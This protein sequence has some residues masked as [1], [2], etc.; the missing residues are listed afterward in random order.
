MNARTNKRRRVGRVDRRQLPDP[1]L[2]PVRLYSSRA[3]ALAT[4]PRP[5]G[6]G[7]GDLVRAFALRIGLLVGGLFGVGRAF[8]TGLDNRA[9]ADRPPRLRGLSGYEGAA[10]GRR[11]DGWFTSNKSANAQ[12]KTSAKSLRARARHLTRNNPHA[13]SAV[14]KLVGATVGVGIPPTSA[15]GIEALDKEANA[16]FSEWSSECQVSGCGGF[17]ALVA[18]AARA[19]FESGEV[20]VRRRPR[21]LEDNLTVPLQLE[22]LE[23][24]LLDQ[25]DNRTLPNGGQVI[26]GVEFDAVGRPVAY[27]LLTSHPGDDHARL[28]SRTGSNRVRLSRARIAH[29]FE[30]QRPGQARGVPWLA[31]VIRRMRDFD[32]YTDAERLRKKIEACLTAWVKGGDEYDGG[33]PA[34]VDGLAPTRVTDSEGI[35][36]EQVEPGLILYL[37]DGKEVVFNAPHTIG[38]YAEFAKVELHG[39]AAGAR[40]TYELLTGDLEKVNFSSI[41]SGKLTWNRT[42]DTLRAHAVIPLLCDRLYDWFV[43]AAISAGLLPDLVEVGAL[44]GRTRPLRRWPRRWHPPRPEAVDRLKDAKADELELGVMLSTRTELLGRR[45]KDFRKVVDELVEEQKI[46]EAAGL[47]PEPVAPAA[48]DPAPEAV[49][50]EDEDPPAGDGDESGGEAA[51]DGAE[52]GDDRGSE[53]TIT[54]PTGNAP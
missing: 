19:M 51:P 30:Q 33:D 35:P 24:D 48:P 22:I 42:I 34:E 3:E 46:L 45:G 37:P 31:P 28:V 38:G 12:I 43:D 29:L 27:H 14:D 13:A 49:E 52:D 40:M 23:A 53:L 41:R 25:Q 32:D 21:R 36:I 5:K 9:Q 11:V 18:L 20:L 8:R 39:I 4:F 47:L 16:L 1:A 54:R 26:Q 15:T 7:L 2:G 17:D 10:K 50:P 6:S 44:M